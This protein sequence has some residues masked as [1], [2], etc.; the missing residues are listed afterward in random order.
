MRKSYTV[1]EFLELTVYGSWEEWYP[2]KLNFAV[3]VEESLPKML[4][5]WAL[6]VKFFS[7]CAYPH[8]KFWFYYLF[9]LF[10]PL[11]LQMSV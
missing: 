6:M 2:T 5:L 1:L 10:S 7:C 4:I 11:I 8:F 9:N 3:G